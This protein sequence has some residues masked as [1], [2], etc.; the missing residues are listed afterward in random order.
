MF[1]LYVQFL[2]DAGLLGKTTIAV[3]GSNFKAVNSR[4]NNYKLSSIE[5]DK[6]N[7]KVHRMLE[8]IIRIKE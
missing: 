2:G 7:A 8:K 6:L 3:D 5:K 4:K 1:R